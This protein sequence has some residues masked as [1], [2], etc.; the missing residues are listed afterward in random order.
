MTRILVAEP[1]LQNA[2]A[3]LIEAANKNG[4]HDNITCLLLRIKG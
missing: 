3:M 2:C 4:G 1:D